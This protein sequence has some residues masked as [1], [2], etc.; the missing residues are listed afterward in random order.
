MRHFNEKYNNRRHWTPGTKCRC[1]SCVLLKFP[2]SL[3][4]TSIVK[5]ASLEKQKREKCPSTRQGFTGESRYKWA[6]VK[7]PRNRN[8]CPKTTKKYHG[9]FY[10]KQP[11]PSQTHRTAGCT[12]ILLFT[13]FSHRW[14]V[15]YTERQQKAI[16][17]SSVFV[18]VFV[19]IIDTQIEWIK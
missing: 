18:L 9:I 5:S 19:I 3:C 16:E 4:L 13:V 6:V 12:S 1:F 8:K 14:L 17:F 2:L 11:Y 7:K 15:K 10:N